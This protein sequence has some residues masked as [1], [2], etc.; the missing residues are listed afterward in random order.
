MCRCICRISAIDSV[1]EEE[2]EAGLAPL[3]SPSLSLSSSHSPDYSLSR[4]YFPSS[5]SSVRPSVR[6]SCPAILA[7]SDFSDPPGIPLSIGLFLPSG[8]SGLARR[9]LSLSLS[10]ALHRIQVIEMAALVKSRS[11]L[12]VTLF[13]HPCS[14]YPESDHLLHPCSLHPSNTLHIVLPLH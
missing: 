7:R 1:I 2:R 9:N 8:A 13:C 6:S 11:R 10:Q 12:P 3:L 4:S 14:T 5:L